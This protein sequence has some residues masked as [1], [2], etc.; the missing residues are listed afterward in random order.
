MT[1]GCGGGNGLTAPPVPPAKSYRLADFTPSGAVSPGKPVTISFRIIQ[2][3]GAP[4]TQF[5]EGPQLGPHTGVHLIL[6]RDDLSQI[7]HRHPPIAAGGVIS[8]TISFPAPG[9]YRLLIDVTRREAAGALQQLSDVS[10]DGRFRPLPRPADRR[11]ATHRLG[12]WL[13]VHDPTPADLAR[14]PGRLPR[15]R[16]ARRGRS[17]RPLHS[18]VR[19]PRPC[20]LLSRAG[21]GLLPHPRLRTGP[22]PGAPGWVRSRA[23]HPS[24]VCCTSACCSPRP[25]CGGCSCNVKIDGRVISAPFTLKVR[26]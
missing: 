18:L 3:S 12:G 13:S 17:S 8:E 14:R 15:R 22:T 23:A 6:V 9:N 2:P 1:T 26:P 10:H 11:R 7:V 21:S 20:H 25:A 4:L 24:R 19:C 5:A 16:R